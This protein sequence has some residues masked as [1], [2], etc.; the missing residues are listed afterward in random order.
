MSLWSHTSSQNIFL[1]SGSKAMLRYRCTFAF[2]FQPRLYGNVHAYPVSGKDNI[3]DVRFLF[4]RFVGHSP[5]IEKGG[6][7]QVQ[8]PYVCAN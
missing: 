7:N 8:I 1:I 5:R 4:S 3:Y 6:L 2:L